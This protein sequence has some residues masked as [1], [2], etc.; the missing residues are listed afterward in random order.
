MS[1][2]RH[3]KVGFLFGLIAAVAMLTAAACAGDDATATPTATA[4]NTPV[5]TATATATATPG[6]GGPLAT[7]TP[8]RTATPTA[9]A[10]AEDMMVIQQGG[11]LIM[12]GSGDPRSFDPHIQPGAGELPYISNLYSFLLMNPRGTELICDLCTDWRIEDGGL[13]I[14]FN[15]VKNATYEDGTPVRAKDVAYSIRKIAGEIDGVASPRCGAMKEYLVTDRDPFELIDD[16]TVKIHLRAPAADFPWYLAVTYCGILADGAQ[17]EVL[18]KVPNGSG[19][20][21]IGEWIPGA[22]F[23]FV[24]R[25]DYFKEGLPY[26]DTFTFFIIP[27][28]LAALGALVTGRIDLQSAFA[29]GPDE[30]LLFQKFVNERDGV[31][32][33][34]ICECF[35]GV[36]MN[37]TEPP[38]NDKKLRHAVNLALDRKSQEAI[39]YDGDAKPVLFM[40]PSWAGARTPDEIWDKIPGWGTGAKKQAEIEEA[41]RLVIEAGFPDGLDVGVL[42]TP[43]IFGRLGEWA[44]PQIEKAGIRGTINLQDRGVTIPKFVEFNYDMGTYFFTT[45][46]PSPDILLAGYFLTGG[47]RNWTGH[48][49]PRIDELFRQQSAENDLQKRIELTRQAEDILLDNMPFAP[50]VIPFFSFV[51]WPYWKGWDTAQGEYFWYK[52]EG[53]YDGRVQ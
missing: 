28:A 21:V 2:L 51:H 11:G 6:V 23:E 34:P 48:S 1:H 43:N 13:S 36:I 32:L 40:P 10:P 24:R 9:T 25:A 7:A 41:K 39:L 4:T 30:K 16:F 37:N 45:G 53:I 14:V 8:T 33:K 22:K 29:A 3:L 35:G 12:R 46:F 27:D 31:W 52:F 49:D 18:T 19:P 20:F 47:S 42:S 17:R 38:F 50:K 15:L 44:V 26:L 5:P